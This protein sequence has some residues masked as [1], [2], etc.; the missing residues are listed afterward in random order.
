METQLN[1]F[2]R[3]APGLLASPLMT[4][5]TGSFAGAAR[6]FQKPQAFG[7]GGWF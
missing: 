4:L 3:R 2:P 1:G 6:K 5:K 7:A